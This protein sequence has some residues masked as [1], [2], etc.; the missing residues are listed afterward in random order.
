MIVKVVRAFNDKYTDEF[1]AVGAR[2]DVADDRA[3]E[4]V[5]AEVAEVVPA[6]TSKA[7]RTTK[8]A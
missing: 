1:H 2:L 7:R 8:K 6:P 3:E 4:L 5:K